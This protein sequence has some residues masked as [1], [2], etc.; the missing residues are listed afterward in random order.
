MEILSNFTVEVKDQE[1]YR[2]LGYKENSDIRSRYLN[3][4]VELKKL[5]NFLVRPISIY[6]IVSAD[7]ISSHRIFKKTEMVAFSVCS[8]GPALEEKVSKFTQSGELTKGLILDAIGSC[9]VE[10]VAD[11]ANFRICTCA[12][13]LDLLASRRF[14]PGYSSWKIEGQ[15]LIFKILDGSKIGVKLLDS[16]MMVPRKSISFAV[17]LSKDISSS[18]VKIKCSRCNFKNCPYRHSSV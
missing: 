13:N 9:V 6:T 12:K 10:E 2:Y 17:N 15:K 1:I 5:S 18:D 7:K 4:I 11:Y 8:I 3:L 16:M 14:S